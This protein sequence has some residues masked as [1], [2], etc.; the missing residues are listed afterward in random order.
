MGYYTLYKAIASCCTPL[1]HG[2][3]AKWS[4]AETQV[5]MAEVSV[6]E[7]VAL[8]C[9]GTAVYS[10]M[11]PKGEKYKAIMVEYEPLEINL[12]HKYTAFPDVMQ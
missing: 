10:V 12:R 4:N 8:E 11:G 6:D 7:S 9:L 5:T 1:D 2:H 3:F